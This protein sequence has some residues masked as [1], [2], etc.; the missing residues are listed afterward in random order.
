MMRTQRPDRRQIKPTAPML[1]PALPFVASL[2]LGAGHSFSKTVCESLHLEAGRGVRGDAHHGITVQHLSRIARDA[3]QP[4]LRQVHL[5]HAELLDALVSVGFHVHPG[6]LGE[7]LTTRRLDLLSLPTGTRLSVGRGAVIEL[8]GLR[9]P[10]A[11]LD[12]F[13]PGL[14]AAVLD[15]RADGSLIRKAGVM[16]VVLSSGE[17]RLGDLLKVQ[18]PAQP[19][20]P[21]A[22][23]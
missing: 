7:N 3:S 9:N 19:H 11:Q 4:N 10:C 5:L 8:T 13:Q 22:P 6:A 20:R 2:S 15:R 17:A 23:V 16:G 14:M 1:E 18:L 12:R 21:L